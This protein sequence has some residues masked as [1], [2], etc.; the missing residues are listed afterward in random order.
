MLKCRFLFYSLKIDFEMPSHPSIPSP[1][2]I[3]RVW[4]FFPASQPGD[5]QSRAGWV[6]ERLVLEP[7]G[8]IPIYYNYI[9]LPLPLFLFVKSV[10]YKDQTHIVP[11]P[12]I[13]NHH[14]PAWLYCSSC[15][16]V[17]NITS[18]TPRPATKSLLIRVLLCYKHTRNGGVGAERENREWFGARSVNLI[19]GLSK[20]LSRPSESRRKSLSDGS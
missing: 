15:L 4:T 12:L 17:L 19:Y 13:R 1:T 20:R 9:F 14:Q 2:L 7:L 5:R 6:I 18:F 16:T 8:P 11:G 10:D 3:N